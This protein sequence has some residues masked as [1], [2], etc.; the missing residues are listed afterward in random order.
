VAGKVIGPSFSASEVVHVVEALLDTY[1]Q[2]RQTPENF[3]ATVR[4]VG[5]EPFRAPANAVR[6]ETGKTAHV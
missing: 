1:L 6:T 5:L 3:I 2:I 4:R